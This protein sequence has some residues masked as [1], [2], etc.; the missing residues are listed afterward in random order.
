V[1]TSTPLMRDRVDAV[2]T[3]GKSLT[4]ELVRSGHV[5]YSAITALD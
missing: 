5:P 4:L 1:L 3:S 2:N